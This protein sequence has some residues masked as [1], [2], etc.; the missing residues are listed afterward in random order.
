[1]AA[2]DYHAEM[3]WFRNNRSHQG[4]DDEILADLVVR[5]TKAIDPS[6]RLDEVAPADFLLPSLFAVSCSGDRV[7][8]FGG[9][10]GLQY[11]A[12]T[13]AFPR[14]KFRWAI[15]EHPL[16]VRRARELEREN[17]RYFDSPESAVAW[18]GHIDLLH[19]NGAL[20]Y[21]DEPEA[22]LRRLLGFKPSVVG[23]S[24]LLI[25]PEAAIETQVARLSDHGPGPL[26]SGITDRDITH[27]TT[28]MTE[29]GFWAAHSGYRAVWKSKDSF[30]FEAVDR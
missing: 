23:Y 29:A 3:R 25:G 10:G 24:R 12:A 6:R 8:D 7:L 17:L 9:G 5:K 20:Q 13:Q 1:M 22:M 4:Y 27:K 21:L 16:M 14:R 30:V 2:P 15:V 11:L 19:S 18:L 28:T 26:P